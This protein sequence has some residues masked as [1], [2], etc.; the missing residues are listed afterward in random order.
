MKEFVKRVVNFIL[1]F[2]RN[3]LDNNRIDKTSMILNSL[4]EKY[5][6]IGKL[7][8]IEHSKVGKYSYM[9]NNVYLPLTCVGRYCS[10]ASNVC[11]AAGMHPLNWVST[12]P[13]FYDKNLWGGV[14]K[15]INPI[16]NYNAFS[17]FNE[18][19]FLCNI[20]ND[21]WIG[22]NALIVC[23]RKTITIGNGSII[24]AG[25][26]V[27]KDV[28]PYTIVGGIPAK[29]IRKRFDDKTIA[30][31]L[32]LRWWDWDEEKIK[33]NLEAIQTGRLKDFVD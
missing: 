32:K 22:T 30:E 1:I 26:V 31:L 21:V 18:D 16:L 33:R 7:T 28:P 10:I 9:G 2:K 25:S 5:V 20:G 23:G 14:K 19:G 29:P 11:L 8:N 17:A 3:I 15:K 4:T 27:T 13:V 6:K 12:S 24:A